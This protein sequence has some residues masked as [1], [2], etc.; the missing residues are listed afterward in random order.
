[1]SLSL[2]GALPD[3]LPIAQLTSL[4]ICS[5]A[6]CP[7]P[8]TLWQRWWA[9]HDGIWLQGRWYCSLACFQAGLYDVLKRLA[10][11]ESRKQAPNN[12]LPLGLILLS[13]G[14]IDADQLRHALERQRQMKQGRI[15]EWLV[16]AGAV[17]EQQVLTALGEQQACPVFPGLEPR[18]IP[19][20]YCWPQ[21]LVD[22][23]GALPVFYTPAKAR[24]YVGFLH[25]VDRRFLYTLE[26]MLG[27]G[28]DPCIVAPKVYRQY[29]QLH[30]LSDA[31][32]TIEILEHQSG[33]EMTRTIGNYAHQVRAE[34]CKVIRCDDLLWVRLRPVHGSHVDFL[35]RRPLLG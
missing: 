28:A 24:V 12:R 15:G 5:S 35:F 14:D 25:Q 33:D 32:E 2:R 26:Q 1:M 34:G 10:L 21:R 4:P 3:S 27:C 8:P 11:T 22:R 18:L 23:Y 7:R 29:V 17:T 9:R 20:V 16:K 13:R 6:F 30:K 31:A 19:S